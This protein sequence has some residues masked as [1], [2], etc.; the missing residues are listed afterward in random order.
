MSDFI[1]G[2]TGGVASGKSEVS[3]RFEALGIGVADADLAA[4]RVVEPGP[5]LERI[6]EVFGPRVLQADGTL[7]RRAL[8]EIVFADD[9]ARRQL[10]AITHPA[11]R[12]LLREACA[13]AGSP[14]AIAA[15]PLLAEA[16]GRQVYPWIDRVLVVDAPEAA[17]HARLVLRDGISAE[18]AERM[19][20]AQAQRSTRLAL[21]DDVVVNDGHPSHLDAAVAELD[22]RYREL[23][24]AKAAFSSQDPAA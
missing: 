6:A 7:E 10:E 21:A 5:A 11:I 3:R 17:Q 19:I 9:E 24:R 23:A 20:A 14:Y 15:I 8:R 13:A 16:G 12:A 2:L 18:L 22:A 4:R 1:I